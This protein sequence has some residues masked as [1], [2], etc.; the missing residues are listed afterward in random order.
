MD[1]LGV[2][3]KRI[4]RYLHDKRRCKEFDYI[5][6][7]TGETV[8]TEEIINLA[9]SELAEEGRIVKVR[10]IFRKKYKHEH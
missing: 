6:G 9:L 4:K 7:I 2:T 1:V 10:T 3:A 5:F 8:D